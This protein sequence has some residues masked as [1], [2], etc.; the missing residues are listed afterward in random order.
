[1]YFFATIL[2]SKSSDFLINSEVI[3][4]FLQSSKPFSSTSAYAAILLFLIATYFLPIFPYASSTPFVGVETSIFPIANDSR[5]NIGNASDSELKAVIS[6]PFTHGKTFV[7]VPLKKTLSS[8]YIRDTSSWTA[9]LSSPSPI[10]TRFIPLSGNLE[11]AL[12]KS[13]IFFTTENRPQNNIYGLHSSTNLL[14]S[15]LL[16]IISIFRRGIGLYIIETRLSSKWKSLVKKSFT[17]AETATTES[18]L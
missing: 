14:S 16:A 1:M 10:R 4:S 8:K 9:S 15:V 2:L 3:Y 11:N 5:Q 17:P 6:E 7:V 18:E 12:I 13:G